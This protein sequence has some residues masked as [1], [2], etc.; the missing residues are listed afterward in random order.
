MQIRNEY[1]DYVENE[2]LPKISSKM[3]VRNDPK[4][5]SEYNFS[6]DESIILPQNSIRNSL[7]KEQVDD[8]F[9]RLMHSSQYSAGSES[10]S[11]GREY[12]ENKPLVINARQ[13]GYTVFPSMIEKPSTRN[14]RS[15][16]LY[17]AGG[18]ILS[19]DVSIIQEDSSIMPRNLI[20]SE[21]APRSDQYPTTVTGIPTNSTVI[22]IRGKNNQ[23]KSKKGLIEYT[24]DEEFII[25]SKRKDV[26]QASQ[27][28]KKLEQY[29]KKQ[30][31]KVKDEI[32]KLEE[33]RKKDE[34]ERK[35]KRKEL[36]D[37]RKKLLDDRR[38]L[39]LKRQKR[40][41]NNSVEATS[42]FYDSSYNL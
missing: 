37:K 33:E 4:F 6:K 36:L 11:P 41:E 32:Y 42:N 9:K 16:E 21:Y 24:P 1:A 31:N 19:Q 15:K 2:G 39:E 34:D 30:L 17:N 13:S 12:I 8:E 27:R 26:I 10:F 22:R 23:Y 5:Q 3:L 28:L 29:E 20:S 38:Q 25:N 7:N 35:I 40:L 18:N 14:Q